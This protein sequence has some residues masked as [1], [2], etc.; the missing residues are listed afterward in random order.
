MLSVVIPARNEEAVIAQTLRTVLEGVRDLDAEIL[1]VDDGSTDAT[2]T[3]VLT[4]PEW[5]PLIRYQTP[6]APF[7][8][9]H[10][11]RRGIAA[12]TGDR[13][14]IMCADGADDPTVLQAMAE[15][16]RAV[17]GDRWT[18]RTPRGYPVLKRLVNRLGNHW[19]AWQAY[20]HCWGTYWDWTDSF[21]GYPG[22]W[23]RDLAPITQATGQA[24]GLELALRW[25]K[26]GRSFAVVPTQWRERTAGTS[27]FRVGTAW[28]YYQVA[29]RLLR[30]T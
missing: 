9:G 28:E 19:I 3:S 27:K 24:L 11:V 30:R 17:F 5:D 14:V 8:Y 15:S 13:V 21:K 7:G 20:A 29:Q 22:G 16:S 1:V 2:A 23:L 18:A 6:V 4:L 10:A 26:T 25:A 12:T